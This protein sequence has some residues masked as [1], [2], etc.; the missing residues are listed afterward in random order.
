[1][2]LLAGLCL[3]SKNIILFNSVQIKNGGTRIRRY[4]S[5][6]RNVLQG[7]PFRIFAAVIPA[8]GYFRVFSAE[9]PESEEKKEPPVKS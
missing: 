1:M 9:K 4:Y 2:I 5:D 6:N 3:T 7:T 8:R